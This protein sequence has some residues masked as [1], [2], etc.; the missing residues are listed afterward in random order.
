MGVCVVGACVARAVYTDV[1]AAFC[2]MDSE[3]QAKSPTFTVGDTGEFVLDGTT[4]VCNLPPWLLDAV[5]GDLSGD[6]PLADVSALT[7]EQVRDLRRQLRVKH[8]FYFNWL[9]EDGQLVQIGV[10][11]RTRRLKYMDSGDYKCA[12]AQCR[13]IKMVRCEAGMLAEKYSVWIA[14]DGTK[15]PLNRFATGHLALQ[16]PGGLAH[17]IVLVHKNE[18]SDIVDT[19]LPGEAT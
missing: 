3:S 2:Q 6:K 12:M 10:N 5:L 1:G 9:P 16:I 17:G 18:P 4:T 8:E 15:L 11:G 13:R 7:T 19:A 14:E